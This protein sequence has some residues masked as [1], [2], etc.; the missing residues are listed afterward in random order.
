[1]RAPK[2]RIPISFSAG[3]ASPGT[4][5][6]PGLTYYTGPEKLT[7]KLVFLLSEGPD[8]ED[9]TAR[10]GTIYDFNLEGGVLRRVTDA[11]S[12]S[13]FASTSGSLYC[14]ISASGGNGGK[15]GTIA[16]VYSTRARHK[17]VTH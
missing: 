11:P 2:K 4:N 8:D 13:L 14:V 10:T 15:N 7:G 9:D 17:G 12:G 5:V 16:F 1:M 6:L 3:C